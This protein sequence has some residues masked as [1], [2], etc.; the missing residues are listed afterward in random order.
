MKTVI[1]RTFCFSTIRRH[2][3]WGNKRDSGK[4]AYNA[5]LARDIWHFILGKSPSGASSF[6]RLM[7]MVFILCLIIFLKV[8]F[9]QADTGVATA[10]IEKEV[11]PSV[12]RKI[13]SIRPVSGDKGLKV[14]IKGDGEFKDYNAFRLLKPNRFVIDLKNIR[15]SVKQNTWFVSSPFVK[16]IR[17]G[18]SHTNMVRIIF[19]LFPVADL[20]CKI[21]S[22]GDRLVVAFGAAS[23]SPVNKYKRKK[24]RYPTK[25]FF[26]KKEKTPQG[27]QKKT[28]AKPAGMITA[29]EV[30]RD[31]LGAKLHIVADG[32]I[33]KFDS[34]FLSESS[35]LVVDMV[36][37]QSA[38]SN[39]TLLFSNP[40][41]K[42]VRLDTTNKDR[43]RVVF[44]LT[45]SAA[46]PT[47]IDSK[48]N[49]I[50]Y[51]V[52]RSP[53]LYAT[54][55]FGKVNSKSLSTSEQA[56][57][58]P[59]PTTW[60]GNKPMAKPPQKNIILHVNSFESESKAY[61]EIHRL[62]KHG[63]NPFYQEKV[64]SGQLWFRVYL[65]PF[66]NKREAIKVGSK[67]RGKAIISHYKLGKLD[68]NVR[69]E[70]KIISPD[71]TDIKLAGTANKKQRIYSTE[72]ISKLPP[73]SADLELKKPLPVII[74]GNIIL[75][76]NLFAGKTQAA[77][78]VK[79]LVTLGYNPFYQVIE[80]ARGKLY[81]V[82][83]GRFKNEQEAL[84]IGSELKGKKIIPYYKTKKI[85]GNVGKMRD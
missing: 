44:D 56:Q 61:N 73:S 36:G 15:S 1:Q 37:V 3:R 49:K 9:V 30:K 29:V 4:V 17:L 65:G 52:E 68:R 5:R 50:V 8:V 83:L 54:K 66:N 2:L 38:V 76:V 84:K 14:Y 60:A 64:V 55:P 67:L 47:Q 16:K 72:K 78:E 26:A 53:D 27:L 51:L 59:F 63:F 57:A 46:P 35:R 45:T 80:V 75:L 62:E 19:D 74:P 71:K 21:L 31:D 23:V 6:S 69:F 20:P 33:T 40:L 12:A 11:N 82:Y 81:G 79:K 18:T 25:N 58:T 24:K 39:E 48:N 22:K 42:N 43:V 85:T 28:P 70:D 32:E 34:F 10:A 7:V 77:E 41:I 13:I